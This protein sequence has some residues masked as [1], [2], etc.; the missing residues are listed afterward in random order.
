[1]KNLVHE[2]TNSAALETLERDLELVLTKV[3]SSVGEENTKSG[4]I[5]SAPQ[6]R[7]AQQRKREVSKHKN[8]QSASSKRKVKKSTLSSVRPKKVHPY[9][10]QSGQR[11]EMRKCY[12]TTMSLQEITGTPDDSSLNCKMPKKC[13]YY[14]FTSNDS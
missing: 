4:L 2:C 14:N 7:P 1:M 13:T 12:K 8:V 9:S 3:E 10:K 5:L 6:K 11:A